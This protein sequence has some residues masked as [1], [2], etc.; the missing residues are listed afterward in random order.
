[1]VPERTAGPEAVSRTH[2]EKP[3][4]RSSYSE[5]T[6]G[7]RTQPGPSAPAPCR[8][9]YPAHHGF[10]AQKHCRDASAQRTKGF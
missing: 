6:C 4:G 3:E 2:G 5:Q 10:K 7:G 8:Q 9:T 1:M